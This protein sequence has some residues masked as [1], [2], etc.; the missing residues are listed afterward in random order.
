MTPVTRIRYGP[1][2]DQH[3]LVRT[4]ARRSR[5][6][7]ALLHGGFWRDTYGAD[8]MAPLADDLVARGWTTANLEYRRLGQLACGFPRLLAD[9]AAALDTLASLDAPLVTIGHSAGGQLSLWA[10][11]RARLPHGAPGADPRARVSY[12]VAQAGVVDLPSAAHARL[13]RGAVQL[14]LGGEPDAVPERYALTSPH[15]LLPLRVPQL[16]VHGDCDT[17]VP[18]TLS[19]GYATAA[20]AAGD[21]VELVLLP[22]VGHFEHLDPDSL[23]WTTVTAWLDATTEDAA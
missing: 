6:T 3:V 16:L 8:L 19:E 5:G 18:A 23:A 11:S 13:G 12:A 9:V 17:D 4:P 10:A 1:H 21:M 7:V 2:Q 14:L 20:A 15:A 22:G